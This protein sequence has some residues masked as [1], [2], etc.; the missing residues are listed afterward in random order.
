MN[1]QIHI[2]RLVLDGLDVPYAQRPA[3]QAALESELARLVSEGGITPGLAGSGGSLARVAGGSI[4]LGE[5]SSDPTALG[6]QIARAIYGSI[7][8]E[9]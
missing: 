1:A 4:E 5:G 6:G 2:D 9:A 3:L 7:G 8:T